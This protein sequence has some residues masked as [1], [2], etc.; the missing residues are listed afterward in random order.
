MRQDL[1]CTASA[2]HCSSVCANKANWESATNYNS[3]TQPPPAPPRQM[4]C[5]RICIRC[6]CLVLGGARPRRASV[7]RPT[8]RGPGS[9]LPVCFGS[10]T[11]SQILPPSRH[12]EFLCRS[13]CGHNLPSISSPTDL[14]FRAVDTEIDSKPKLWHGI[15][16]D[17]DH[18]RC[19]SSMIS[20]AVTLSTCSPVVRPATKLFRELQNEHEEAKTNVTGDN[21]PIHTHPGGNREGHSRSGS[22]GII[23]PAPPSPSPSPWP[24]RWWSVSSSCKTNGQVEKRHRHLSSPSLV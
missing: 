2:R 22:R 17:R 8:A 1:F 12:I 21:C 13:V 19:P 23:P 16:F 10:Q 15:S 14:T 4:S 7:D 24:P 9:S 5:H 3:H 6:K 11:S 18:S 20:F